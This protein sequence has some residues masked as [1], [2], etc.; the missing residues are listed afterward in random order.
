MEPCECEQLRTLV[1]KLIDVA[2]NATPIHFMRELD[3]VVTEAKEIRR[4]GNQ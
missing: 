1:D 3:K 2:D 4:R